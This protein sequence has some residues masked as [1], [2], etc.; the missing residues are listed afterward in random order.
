MADQET[1]RGILGKLHART[2]LTPDE[3]SQL[4]RHV[5][6]LE[7]QAISAGS[8]HHTHST[9]GSHHSDHVTT[10]VDVVGVLERVAL[11]K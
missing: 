1:I 3:L 8:N 6:E 2:S 11:R 5:D 7:T 10:V 4:Q 9:P